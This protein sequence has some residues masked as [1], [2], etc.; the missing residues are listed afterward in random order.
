MP[1]ENM[2]I[3]YNKIIFTKTSNNKKNLLTDNINLKHFLRYKKRCENS[4]I[5]FPC[6]NCSEET[7]SARVI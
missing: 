7:D 5:K 1:Y 3:V 6:L 4:S 2:V